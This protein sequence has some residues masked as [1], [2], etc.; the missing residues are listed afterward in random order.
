[1]TYVFIDINVYLTCFS[2]PDDIYLF[3]ANI[4]GH[5]ILIGD[6]KYL[7]WNGRAWNSLELVF[8]LIFLINHFVVVK[9]IIL[10]FRRKLGK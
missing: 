9:V 1:M 8:I 4:L 7:D 6:R 10:V 2:A 3:S 5:V